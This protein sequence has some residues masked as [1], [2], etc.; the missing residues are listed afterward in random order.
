[1]A[2]KSN[3]HV[4]GKRAEAFIEATPDARSAPQKP[5]KEKVAVAFAPEELVE[6]DALC[7]VLGNLPRT[8][9]IRLALKRLAQSEI[10]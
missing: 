4:G 5:A 6:L 1:M 2:V 9:C 7:R 10:N 8:S 3:P